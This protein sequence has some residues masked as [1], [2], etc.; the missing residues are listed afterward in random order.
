[1]RDQEQYYDEQMEEI[2]KA[3]EVAELLGWLED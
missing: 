1:M 3:L 2:E